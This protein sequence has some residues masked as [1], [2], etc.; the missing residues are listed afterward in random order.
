MC[1][2]L[3]C[4][5]FFIVVVKFIFF[6]QNTQLISVLIT[7][8][9]QERRSFGKWLQASLF[10]Q[11]EDLQ[12]LYTYLTSAGHLN[13]PKFLEKKRVFRKIFPNAPFNDAKL[14]QSIHFLLQQLEAFLLF[15]YQ[16]KNKLAQQL[17]LAK[18]YRERKVLGAFQRQY[19]IT[20]KAFEQT[21]EKD[22]RR[23]HLEY[24]LRD[25]YITFIN[26]QPKKVSVNFQESIDALD[27]Y[28]IAEKLKQACHVIAHKKVFKSE[29]DIRLL[30][31]ILEQVKQEPRLAEQAS[32]A[33]YYHGYLMQTE[34]DPSQAEQHYFYLR[35]VIETELYAFKEAERQDI[36]L[37]TL[38]YCVGKMN[39]GQQRFVREAFEIYQ[40]GLEEQ[41][42][43]KNGVLSNISYL[44]L[45]SIGL[46]LKEFD[47]I[48]MYIDKY[49]PLLEEQHRDNLKQFAMAKLLFERKEYDEAMLLLFQFES[50][51][52]I[53]SLNAKTM[54]LK[55]YYE[56][57]EIDALES[58]L[59]S[60]RA[61]LKRKEV[62]GYHKANYLNII[63]Y[64]RKLVRV[65]PYDKQ[66]C[67]VLKE[68]IATA[69]PLTERP[70][71]LEQMQKLGVT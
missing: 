51:H 11:R 21:A 16:K 36:Y 40:K 25:Q 52:I 24:E 47:W 71:L 68:E 9:K 29:Y 14:R 26:E 33:V 66:K 55:M 4:C 62:I 54:L 2:F 39:A 60:L 41:M 42:I 49:T 13:D 10:N 27:R 22:T 59:D 43:I 6:V 58:L 3:V 46:R 50:K 19:K 48:E 5:V 69:S 7:L 15:E 31:Y 63:K 64:T 70:W 65:N 12:R 35:A 57:D 30:P 45:L 23:L 32:I 67:L 56:K 53:V 8:D 17:L 20:Q 34:Q 44:N 38:N 1:C 28:L 37:M 61:Y 18:V